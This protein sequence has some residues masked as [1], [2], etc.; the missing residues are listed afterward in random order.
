MEEQIDTLN[1]ETA[2]LGDQIVALEDQISDKQE[3]IDANMELL[4][5]RLCALY[6]AGDASTLEII[7]NSENL[8]DFCGKT[9]FIKAVTKHD[10]GAPESPFRRYGG[11]FLGEGRKLRD[12]KAQV[13]Q[14]KKELD[15]KSL[16]LSD[17]Y[18]EGQ[19][20]MEELN[21]DKTDA[22][23]A[24]L[25]WRVT[26]PRQRLAID[27]WFEDYYAQQPAENGGTSDDNGS[28]DSGS[29][30]SGGSSGGGDPAGSECLPGRYQALLGSLPIGGDGRNHQAIDIAGSGI[31]GQPI[32]A[33][34]SRYGILCGV[35]R[36]G[37]RLWNLADYRPWEWL[38]YGLCPLQRP[39][40][41]LGRVG[42]P[43]TDYRLC[44]K[45]RGFHRPASAF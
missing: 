11:Y 32:V 45:H 5:D 10:A 2:E 41:R 34:A 13:L 26:F 1:A 35:R 39:C 24:L 29:G 3:E 37:R 6:V 27:A 15:D 28:G 12:T 43:G 40:G 8:I 33:A 17:L 31:Y 25:R 14:N 23:S 7:L 9:E 18:E 19:A 20:V 42:F 4:K 44:G 30:N 21:A 22:R 36:L 16:E 38:F